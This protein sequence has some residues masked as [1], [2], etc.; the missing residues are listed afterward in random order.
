MGFV[1]SIIVRILTTTW[2]GNSVFWRENASKF[3]V[4]FS[5]F[6]F[7]SH[8][9]N[10]HPYLSIADASM[11]IV[12]LWPTRLDWFPRSLG[13]SWPWVNEFWFH[14]QLTQ[15]CLDLVENWDL[16]MVYGILAFQVVIKLDIDSRKLIILLAVD[17]IRCEVVRT[18]RL[19]KHQ[20]SR[21]LSKK[22]KC[23]SR[24]SHCFYKCNSLKMKLSNYPHIYL[25]SNSEIVV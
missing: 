11:W 3:A 8:Y 17:H 24:M 6:C 10:L 21:L 4:R 1:V 14:Y 7:I 23:N 25:T 9:K 18:I 19:D 22:R 16:R 13:L 20:S 5:L 15:N 2:V 12:L